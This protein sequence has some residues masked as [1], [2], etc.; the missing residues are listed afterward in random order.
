M[1]PLVVNPQMKKVAN[2]QPEV[3]IARRHGEGRQRQAQRVLQR[4]SLGDAHALNGA[5]RQ[6]ADIGGGLTHE[7]ENERDEQRR[8]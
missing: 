7:K 5:K 2:S 4:L 1:S 6:G 3:V 8:R